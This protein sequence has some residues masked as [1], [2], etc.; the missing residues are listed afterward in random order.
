MMEKREPMRYIDF[1]AADSQKKRAD[2]S[3][4]PEHLELFG[5]QHSDAG[6]APLLR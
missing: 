4:F 3:E 6:I 1:A 5:L 2:F